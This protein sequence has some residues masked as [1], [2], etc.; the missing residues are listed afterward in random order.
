[1]SKALLLYTLSRLASST[2]STAHSIERP[3]VTTQPVHCIDIT[4]DSDRQVC[5][6]HYTA[7]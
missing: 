6:G 4:S 3:G 2:K 5:V 1:V 7:S